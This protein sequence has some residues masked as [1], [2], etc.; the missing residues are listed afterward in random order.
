VDAREGWKKLFG[1]EVI[2]RAGPTWGLDAEGEQHGQYR[3]TGQPGVSADFTASVAFLIIRQLWY[4]G[5][6]FDF[7]RWGSKTMVSSVLAQ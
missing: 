1:D 7:S 4:G 3:P 2:E 5:G 6:G